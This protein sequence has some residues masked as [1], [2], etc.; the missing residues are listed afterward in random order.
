[1]L[2]GLKGRGRRYMGHEKVGNGIRENE[3]KGKI[4]Y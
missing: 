2:N 1:M 4:Y 3:K